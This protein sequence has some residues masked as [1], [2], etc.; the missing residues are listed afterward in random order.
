MDDISCDPSSAP[1][2]DSEG[3]HQMNIISDNECNVLDN[4]NI[5]AKKDDE[6][7][8]VENGSNR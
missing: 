7:T 4:P 8:K 2:S 1:L 3:Q 6:E 5:I